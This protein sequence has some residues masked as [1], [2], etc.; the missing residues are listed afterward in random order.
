MDE[1]R[2]K[3]K[4]LRFLEERDRTNLELR[5]ALDE[6]KLWRDA[7]AKGIV[8]PEQANGYIESAK[9]IVNSKLHVLGFPEFPS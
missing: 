1:L 4:L 3:N 5:L 7:A 8:K 2:A 6:I 9:R